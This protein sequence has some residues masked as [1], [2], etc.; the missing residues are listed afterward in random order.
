MNA[1]LEKHKPY[2]IGFRSSSKLF[3]KVL[4]TGLIAWGLLSFRIMLE[5]IDNETMREL[6]NLDIVSTTLN[7]PINFVYLVIF[8][9]FLYGYIN[10]LITSR[11]I[12]VP[13][14]LSD[15]FWFV[16]PCF[17]LVYGSLFSIRF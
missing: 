1:L 2:F 12:K 14:K 10:Y 8:V 9:F 16:L 17:L 11:L 13:I 7:R 4:S 3:I 15:V 5:K 6:N